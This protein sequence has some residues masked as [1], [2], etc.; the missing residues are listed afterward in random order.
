M[1]IANKSRVLIRTKPTRLTR[2]QKE[3]W[4]GLLFISPWLLGFVLWKAL[5][6]LAAFALSLTNFKMIS[7]EATKFIG[8]QNYFRL[9][10]D[11]EAGAS[12]FGSLSYFL[13]TVPLEMIVALV[14]AAIFTS[15][16]LKNKRL[17]QTLIF[18]TSIIPGTSVFFIFLG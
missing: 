7:P 3:A 6:I 12:L 9:V 13:L 10:R 4:I 18:M 5:P 11:T 16:R 1:D 8:L 15:P 17:S 14:L 2:R